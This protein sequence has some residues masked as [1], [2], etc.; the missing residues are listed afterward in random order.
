MRALSDHQNAVPLNEASEFI[1]V[2]ITAAAVRVGDRLNLA[3]SWFTV[4]CRVHG[5]WYLDVPRARYIE[6][7]IT[8]DTPGD[9]CFIPSVLRFPKET[10]VVVYRHAREQRHVATP[11]ARSP[12][13]RRYAGIR[14]AA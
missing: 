5:A 10:G 7:E 1:A 14:G 4:T 9:G 8:P 6:F 12:L 2:E 3:G 11:E 13:E